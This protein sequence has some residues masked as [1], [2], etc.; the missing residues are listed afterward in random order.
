MIFKNYPLKILK[1][2]I[3]FCSDTENHDGRKCVSRVLV[4]KSEFAKIIGKGGVTVNQIKTK[5]GASVRGVEIDDEN[6]W[7]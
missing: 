3:L 5:C 7:T 1:L 6:R 2:F 4:K